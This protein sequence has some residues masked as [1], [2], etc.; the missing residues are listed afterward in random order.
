MIKL[1]EQSVELI[2][3]DIITNVIENM[4]LPKIQLEVEQWDPLTDLVPIH[5]WIHPWLP[6]LSELKLFLK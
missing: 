3:N 1:V 4:I 5:L 2:P 6:Y